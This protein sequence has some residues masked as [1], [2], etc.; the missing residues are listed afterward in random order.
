MLY[1]EMDDTFERRLVNAW[2]R[3]KNSE[4]MS[5]AVYEIDLLI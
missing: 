5:G 2:K 1:M 3:R 4:Q